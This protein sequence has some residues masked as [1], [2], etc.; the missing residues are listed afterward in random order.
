[1]LSLEDIWD[2]SLSPEKRILLLAVVR[3]SCGGDKPWW[4]SAIDESSARCRSVNQTALLF[5]NHQHQLHDFRQQTS[6]TVVV[7]IKREG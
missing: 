3:E 4:L 7:I 1:M 5:M 6:V 2:C